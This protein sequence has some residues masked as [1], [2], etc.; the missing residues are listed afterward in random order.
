MSALRMV[1]I[2]G[3]RECRRGGGEADPVSITGVCGPSPP[4]VDWKVSGKS[5]F[6]WKRVLKV[7][8]GTKRKK[9]TK[10]TTTTKKAK[11]TSTKR[12]GVGRGEQKFFDTVRAVHQP[13]VAGTISNLSL[14]LI[15]QGVDENE[16]VGRKCTV[17]KVMLRGNITTSA[18]TAANATSNICRIIVYQDKQANGATATV[19][20]ILS[21]ATEQSYNN[22]SNSGRFKIL[23][24]LRNPGACPSGSGRGT[25]D[26]LAFGEQV[27]EF[28]WAKEV[29]IPLEFGTGGTGAITEL[30][31]N[32][33]GV[34]SIVSSAITDLSYVARVRFSD[35]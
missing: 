15:V 7:M 6:S 17:N 24:D 26:T 5:N 16:R 27:K 23:M 21:T 32:N 35:N 1:I 9:T 34:L 14:N 20:N 30:R 3:M 4:G 12:T 18:Q 28:F 33:I 22:L 31:S 10:A 8:P 19:T 11:A 29:N 25:T 13:A 2:L